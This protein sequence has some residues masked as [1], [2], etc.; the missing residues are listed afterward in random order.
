MNEKIREYIEGL[1]LY[2]KAVAKALSD[3][4]FNPR[5]WLFGGDLDRYDTLMDKFKAED[6]HKKGEK[7]K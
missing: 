5:M 7:C 1:Q 3:T 6:E 4:E 2:E